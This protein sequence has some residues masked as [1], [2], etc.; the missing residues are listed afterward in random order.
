MAY[1]KRLADDLLAVDDVDAVGRRMGDAAALQVVASGGGGRRGDVAY[2]CRGYI[3]VLAIEVVAHV[4]CSV[5]CGAYALEQVV[6]SWQVLVGLI[7]AIAV[8]LLRQSAFGVKLVDGGADDMLVFVIAV[9]NVTSVFCVYSSGFH[10][11]VNAFP[12]VVRRVPTIFPY[13]SFQINI[14]FIGW[15]A[16]GHQWVGV[17]VLRCMR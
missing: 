5:G 3:I 13:R 1:G 9:E 4:A 11:S 6:G 7:A 8:F 2:A 16:E 15:T 14:P 10:R 17:V 12:V